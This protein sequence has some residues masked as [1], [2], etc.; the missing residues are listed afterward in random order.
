M[1]GGAGPR[2]AGADL[3][4]HR[5]ALRAAAR[6]LARNSAEAEDLVQDAFERAL[7]HLAD[8]K[9]APRNPRAWL[10]TILHN[11]FIDRVRSRRQMSDKV[12]DRP[13]PEPEPEPVWAETTLDDVRRAL[14]EIDPD[15][16]AAFE[17]HYLEGLRYREVARRLS[18]PEN[19]VASR[20]FRA[21]LALRHKLLASS[22]EEARD[23]ER[24][25]A[26]P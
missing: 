5:E 25:R 17:L 15:L 8:G 7:R 9:P 26:E 10:V 19:T 11:A 6:A 21:R 1:R 22:S 3:A 2:R 13:A 24:V 14:A 23:E 20:L 16:R 12:E 18:I 4:C